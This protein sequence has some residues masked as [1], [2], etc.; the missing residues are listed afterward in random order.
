[1]SLN[2]APVGDGVRFFGLGIGQA[3]GENAML[4]FDAGAVYHE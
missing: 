1:V 2:G 4:Q 3:P